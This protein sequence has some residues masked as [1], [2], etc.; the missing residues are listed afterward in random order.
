M[1][2]VI[3]NTTERV[4]FYAGVGSELTLYDVDIDGA[5]L[6]KRG[7]T[8]LPANVQYAWQ[9][10]SKRYLYVVS[11]NRGP[12][13]GPR[14]EEPAEV[15]HYISAYR[16]DPN[17]GALQEHGALVALRHR[18]LHVTTDVPSE[19][20]LVAYNN[21]STLTVH[22]INPDGSIGSE[23]EQPAS[24]DAGIFAHQI[25]VAPANTIAI[26]VTRGYDAA[27]GKPEQPGALKV[28]DYRNGLLSNE[29]SIA[30]G[31]G[32]GFGPRHLDF[33]PTQPWVYVSLE[34]QHKICLFT[35]DRDTLSSEPL[36]S[37]D[38]LAEPNNVRPGQ[39]ASTVHVHPNGRFVYGAERVHADTESVFGGGE[40]S[41][42][43]YA[44]DE[45]T[46][47]PTFV[48][49]VDTRGIHP[50]T[51]AIHPSGRLLIAANKSPVLVQDGS[52]TRIVPASLDVFRMGADGKLTY[53]RKYDIDVSNASMFWTG[54]VRL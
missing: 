8:T 41:I 23:V 13:R 25:R 35:L 19:H 9:H 47:K 11:S 29:V 32:Y 10:A 45:R 43:V 37:E 36:F 24:L 52:K 12:D 5:A 22:R 51:F 53:A 42:I 15:R 49:R 14:A 21:P 39:M 50:R 54:L 46:G 28:F 31:G 7:S 2:N 30:P 17:S 16:V 27:G 44:I 38:T 6:V 34:R 1:A 20:A 18:P 40:N 26:L 48:Q 4:V 33:H 3:G